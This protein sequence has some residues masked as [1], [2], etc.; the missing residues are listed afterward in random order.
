MTQLRL[1]VFMSKNKDKVKLLHWSDHP[2]GSTKVR[3]QD[4][5]VSNLSEI[6]FSSSITVTGSPSP[7]R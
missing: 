1:K 6:G 2:K 7:N 3:I 5:L 4:A